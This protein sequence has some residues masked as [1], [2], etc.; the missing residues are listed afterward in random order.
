MVLEPKFTDYGSIH[1]AEVPQ[2]LNNSHALISPR[3]VLSTLDED[4]VPNTSKNTKMTQG[5]FI[6]MVRSM[7][8]YV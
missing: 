8:L 1:S 6:V 7:D 5:W 2:Q 4:E 3:S